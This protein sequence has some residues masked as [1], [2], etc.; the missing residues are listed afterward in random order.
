MGQ[1]EGK[2]ALITGAGSGIGLGVAERFVEEG[3]Y[4]WLL[5]R[6]HDAVIAAAERLGERAHALACDVRVLPDVEDAFASVPGRLDVVVANAGVQLIGEDAPVGELD[7]K[8]WERTLAVNMTGTFHT[9][10]C[11]V[12]RMDGQEPVAGSRGS[13]AVTG[14][15][16]GV[17]GEGAGFTA[18]SATK[19]GTHGLA[20][21]VA[22]DYAARSIRVNVVVPGHTLT[23]LVHAIR[24]NPE[25]SRVIDG[26]IPMGRPG[27]V[28]DVT[29]AYVYLASDDSSYAT[30]GAIYVDGGMTNL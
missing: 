23:P 10:R 2:H 3:A 27:E 21:T 8:V 15:P 30:G 12:R 14:S 5:D 4:V 7:P 26:R 19:A 9:L 17:T 16:T 1:L 13:I 24:T 25:A 22:R 6:S 18:Y 20:R 28:R 29:G 11:A